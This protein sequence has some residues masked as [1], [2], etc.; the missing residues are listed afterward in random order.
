[1]ISSEWFDEI[2]VAARYTTTAIGRVQY[3]NV[4]HSHMTATNQ[5][6]MNNK[7]E[8]GGHGINVY[9]DP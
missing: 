5:S 2:F 7:M 4:F 3:A 8:D 9:I 6:E 1:M